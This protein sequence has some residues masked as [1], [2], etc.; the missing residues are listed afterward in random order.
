MTCWKKEK[1]HEK[2]T[3][4]SYKVKISMGQ[5]CKAEFHV[6]VAEEEEVEVK[7]EVVEG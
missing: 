3:R 2:G 1:A 4:S 7:L 5:S 6:E